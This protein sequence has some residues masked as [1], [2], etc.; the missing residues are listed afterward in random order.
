MSS[1]KVKGIIVNTNCGD[2]DIKYIK[3]SELERAAQITSFSS[4]L[5]FYV[6]LEFSC[7]EFFFRF[8]NA[9]V[10]FLFVLGKNQGLI[11]ADKLFTAI[12]VAPE[13]GR[14]KAN[15]DIQTNR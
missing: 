15:T 14:G 12:W 1:L 5:K 3:I 11:W 10:K 13:P 8:A 4:S 9:E 6:E 2:V 7:V